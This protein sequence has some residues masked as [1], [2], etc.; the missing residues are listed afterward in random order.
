M[1]FQWLLIG[2]LSLS[3]HE[4]KQIPKYIKSYI[5]FPQPRAEGPSADAKCS[6]PAERKQAEH[7][8][9]FDGSVSEN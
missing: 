5:I 8:M 9:R 6:Q 2:T 1:W 4:K 3:L 7:A